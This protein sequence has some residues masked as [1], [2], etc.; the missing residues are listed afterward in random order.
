MGGHGTWHLG[1][2]YPDRWAA[3]S[4]M[5]GWR[6][7]FS[8]T[9]RAAEEPFT[10]IEIMINRASNSSRTIEM[11]KNYHQHGVF[12]EHGDAD[13]TVRVSEARFMREQLA[14]FHPSLGY[15]EEPGGGHWYGVDHDRVF[16]F[17]KDHEKTDIRDLGV[18]EFRIASPGVSSTNRYITLY[19]QESIDEYCGVVAKQ[20]IRTRRQRRNNQDLSQRKMEIST[21]NLKTFRVDLVHC[22]Q[23]ESLELFVDE[24]AI[25]NL[26]WPSRNHV[27]LDKTNGRWQVID[28]P[29]N[30]LEKNPNR[31]GG[32]KE[33]FNHRF[34]LVYSTGGDK[35]ENEWSYNK[36]RF[37]AE[38]FYYRGNSGMDVIPDTDFSLEAYQDRSVIL[39]GN[40]DTNQAWPVLLKDS[41]VQ[42]KRG[43]L[44]LGDKRFQ[45][46][47]YGLY[48]VRPRLDSKVALV[49]VIAGTGRE[50][51]IAATPNRY[52]IS[53]PGFPDLI[54]MTPEMFEEG[55]EGI[56]AAGY[57]G[58]D[59]SVKNGDFAFG[60]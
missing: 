43:Q 34:V 13:T 40:A 1:A 27:W 44:E 51:R 52:F 33:A 30:H 49:G 9:R 2:T 50:G 5:A 42:I 45:G 14:A 8:Y 11:I 36:A 26:P 22:M 37:D 60:E 38:T 59:W 23:L 47:E 19:Q 56:V 6:S 15:H 4:P 39:Y 35:A 48:M 7:F 24:Q 55:L 54:I 10:P 57:F 12:I 17:F 16:H 32:I 53:G 31:Y 28:K 20:T 25:E 29:T 58:N 21:E 41:P 3:I 18:L 46:N